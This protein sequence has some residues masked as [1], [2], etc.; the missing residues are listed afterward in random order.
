MLSYQ[1]IKRTEM[2]L[3]IIL[4]N[5]YKVFN[6]GFLSEK[7]CISLQTGGGI[8]HVHPVILKPLFFKGER[9][10]KRHCALK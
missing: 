5:I 4:I 3:N 9:N 10:L 1:Y 2:L 7:W 6:N 8:V